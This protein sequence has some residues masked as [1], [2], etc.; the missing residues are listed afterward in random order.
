[1]ETLP[2][3]SGGEIEDNRRTVGRIPSVGSFAAVRPR[4]GPF[5]RMTKIRV[6]VCVVVY[7]QEYGDQGVCT[8]EHDY[9][10]TCILDHSMQLYENHANVFKRRQDAPE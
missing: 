8:P 3:D 10:C 6:L 7:V 2:D 9:V 1:M 4:S 5:C